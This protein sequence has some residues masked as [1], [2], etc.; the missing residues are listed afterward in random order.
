MYTLS[1]QCANWLYL[2]PPQRMQDDDTRL[3]TIG[4]GTQRLWPPYLYFIPL[5]S[6]NALDEHIIIQER[7]SSGALGRVEDDNVSG[8]GRPVT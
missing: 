8:D 5:H 7:R 3:D 4:Q 2:T 6:N 1:F